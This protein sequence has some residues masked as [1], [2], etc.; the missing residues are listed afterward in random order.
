MALQVVFSQWGVMNTLFHTAPLTL[1]QWLI[2]LAPMIP[3]IP[4]AIFANWIDPGPQT[5]ITP[6]GEGFGP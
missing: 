4:M 5:G 1:Q 2:C 3:M 6:K